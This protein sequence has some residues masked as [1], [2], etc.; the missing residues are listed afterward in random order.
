MWAEIL[1]FNPFHPEIADVLK[2]TASLLYKN[3][4]DSTGVENPVSFPKK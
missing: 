4:A 2:K 3:P 1:V